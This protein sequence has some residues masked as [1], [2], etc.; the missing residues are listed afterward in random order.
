MTY[1][2][3]VVF[4]VPDCGEG[5]LF[6][7]YNQLIPAL[8]KH[9]KVHVLFAS[10]FDTRLTPSIPSSTSEMIRPESAVELRRSLASGPLAVAPQL[11][12]ALGTAHLAWKR[13]LSLDPDIVEICDWPLGMAPA[14]LDPS[15]PSVIQCHGS[16]AQIAQF[17]PQP[18]RAVESMLLRLIEPQLLAQALEVQAY[19]TANAHSWEAAT[20]RA[21]RVIRPAFVCPGLQPSAVEQGASISVFGRLQSWKGPQVLCEALQL[22]GTTAPVCDWYGSAKPWP[23][24]GINA[25]QHLAT[26]YPRVWGKTFRFHG[27]VDRATV[28]RL[29]AA[30]RAVIV[31]STWDTFNFTAAEAMAMARPLI[32][33]TG[34]GV[35]EL[36]EDGVNGFAFANG[37]AASLALAI[38]RLLA[39][40]PAQARQMGE[41]ARE[42]VRQQLDPDMIAAQ[43]HNVY[44]EVMARHA[45]APPLPVSPWLADL[46]TPGRDTGF[47]MSAFLDTLPARPMMKSVSKRL[48]AKLW[49]GF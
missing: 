20:A 33:S 28:A 10:M 21:V 4:I 31:P 8:A 18:N 27:P 48:R 43:R 2:Q 41:A 16:M 47:D 9:A 38:A 13:A 37:D 45:A 39:Q 23:D 22:L 6:Q 44:G 17:D 12:R 1:P 3:R 11:S 24:S 34:A 25:D 36:I 46:L 49:S 30:S 29:Q 19:S 35:S 32:V 7:F 14:V 26:T 40:S 5:G 42:T 15:V